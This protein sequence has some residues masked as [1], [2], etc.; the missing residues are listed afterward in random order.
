[1]LPSTSTQRLRDTHGR[2]SKIRL[3]G[4]DHRHHRFCRKRGGDVLQY[5]PSAGR[6]RPAPLMSRCPSPAASP[7]ASSR[8]SKGPSDVVCPRPRPSVKESDSGLWKPHASRAGIH[9]LQ[10]F[11]LRHHP[12]PGVANPKFAV[13][14]WHGAAQLTTRRNNRLLCLLKPD[15]SQW[16]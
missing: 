8:P 12:D 14:S 4:R 13:L 16:E 3:S 15:Y 1:L 2:Q 10:K 5:R 7:S 6:S 11:K 9:P